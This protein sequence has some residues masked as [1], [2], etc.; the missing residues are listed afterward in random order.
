MLARSS[1]AFEHICVSLPSSRRVWL[2]KGIIHP[3]TKLELAK[4]RN[5]S[6]SCWFHSGSLLIFH[7]SGLSC[8][9]PVTLIFF[10]WGELLP[11]MHC[12]AACVRDSC[13]DFSP[14]NLPHV[15]VFFYLKPTPD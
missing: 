11:I 9:L 4:P 6:D 7:C 15:H 1:A 5:Q 10:F 12:S 13:R 3:K 8:E 14:L 2:I